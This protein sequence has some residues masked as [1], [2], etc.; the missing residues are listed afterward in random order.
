MNITGKGEGD[1]DT[2]LTPYELLP[3]TLQGVVICIG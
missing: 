3:C 1:G 2:L